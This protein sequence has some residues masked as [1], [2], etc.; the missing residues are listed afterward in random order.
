MVCVHRDK[1]DNRC[2]S[3]SHHG[4]R[5]NRDKMA[6]QYGSGDRQRSHD[7]AHWGAQTLTLAQH[8]DGNRNRPAG[9]LGT[10]RYHL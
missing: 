1:A 6:H 2:W 5:D 3:S 10:Q 4:L 7:H 9:N 8:P